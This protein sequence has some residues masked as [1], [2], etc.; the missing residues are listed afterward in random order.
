MRRNREGK[1]RPT[2]GGI[3][4]LAVFAAL[5]VWIIGIG[6]KS[7]E[8]YRMLSERCTAVTIGTVTSI[9]TE[10][11]ER[12]D[13]DGNITYDEYN[14]ITVTYYVHNEPYKITAKDSVQTYVRD[15]ELAVCYAPDDPDVSYIEALMPDN[16][17]TFLTLLGAFCIGIGLLIF[18]LR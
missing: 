11:K 3:L 7:A 4:C 1:K 6:F 12:E 15:E 5:G 14:V 13:E 8:R 2:I 18:M 9:R 16:D 10:E 17:Q